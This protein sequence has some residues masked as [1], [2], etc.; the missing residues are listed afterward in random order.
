MACGTPGEETPSMIY[1]CQTPISNLILRCTS[2]DA[3]RRR[4]P[5][6]EA[7]KS[8]RNMAS[9]YLHRAAQLIVDSAGLMTDEAL[10]E[11]EATI[12]T[13]LIRGNK[14]MLCGNGGSAADA[15]HLAAELLVRLRPDINRQGI[16]AIALTMDASTLTAQANDYGFDGIFERMVETIG[17]PGD[18]LLGISTSGESQNVVRA[19]KVARGMEIATIGLLG[20][21]G[22]KALAACDQA[23]VVPSDETAMIQTVHS[24]LGHALLIGVEDAL[25]EQGFISQDGRGPAASG[26]AGS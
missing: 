10:S 26:Q 20:S 4:L 9:Q 17:N 5:P 2:Q 1:R 13:A 25:L 7:C 11:M 3:M 12:S 14:L 15:Q 16:P 21:G 18:V 24:A 6:R 19:L 23:F 22:G 8:A